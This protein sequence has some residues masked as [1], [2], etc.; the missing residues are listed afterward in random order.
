MRLPLLLT[1]LLSAITS[2][3]EANPQLRTDVHLFRYASVEAHGAQGAFEEFRH[4]LFEQ[5]INL[6]QSFVD[7]IPE[8][9][10]LQLKMITN[11][12]TN[13]LLEPSDK[14]SSFSQKR[15]YW[16]EE[17]ALAILTGRISSRTGQ[18]DFDIISIIFWDKLDSSIEK[19][20][21]NIRVPLRG[22]YYDA[23]K[24]LHA[25]AVLYA[26]A[27]HLPNGGRSGTKKIELL[28]NARQRICSLSENHSMLGTEILRLVSTALNTESA[29]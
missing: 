5:I 18:S 4:T 13:T 15:D 24:D 19:M 6:G 27:M 11:Q 28:S 17:G 29:C 10:D 2:P 20:S 3:I 26:F 14:F 22:V 25:A 7:R 21:V 23:S 16:R 8:T 12:D 9:A 1:V